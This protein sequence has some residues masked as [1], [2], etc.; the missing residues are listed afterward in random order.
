MQLTM[1]AWLVLMAWAQTSYGSALYSFFTDLTIQ[2]GA[3]DPTTGKLLYSAC[4]SQNIPIFPLEKPNILDTK[5]TPRNGTALTAVGWGDWQFITAQVFWQTEDDTIVQGKYI[6]NMTTGKLVRDREFQISAAAGVDSIHNQTGLS[7]VNLGEKDGYRLFYHDKDRKV[8]MLWYTDDD[9]WNDGGAI[10]QDTAGGMALG[11]TIHDLK[12]ITVPFPK[13]SENIEL[14][15]LDK[16]GLWTLDAFPNK[17]LGPYTNNTLPADMF[18]SLED[19]ADF[20]LPAWNSSLEAIGA[21]V[22]RDRSRTR[23]IFYI[24]D[25]KKIHEVKSTNSGWQLGSNQTERTWPVADNAS[26]GLAVVSQQSEGKAW[27]YYWSNETIVQAFKDYD[28][29]WVDAEALPQKVPTNGTDDKK[30]KDRPTQEDGPDPEGSKGLSSG[31]KTG[32][33]VGVGIGV[34]ALLIDVLAWL[35]TKRR[36]ERAHQE[37]VSGIVEVG[38]SPLEPRL[39]VF[40]EDLPRENERVEPS[41]MAGQ[42]RP[43][44]LSHH[45]SVVY[46]LPEHHA[47]G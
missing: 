15:R 19:E 11:S 46:E 28:G 34:G 7:I 14:S 36:R 39:Y 30:P 33:G 8:K 4:N 43:A 20:S 5:E 24:G 35:W 37:K 18:W 38:G 10:S 12:N 29:D 2:V 47:R 16:S 41:E 3:Q 1:L 22:D 9:G 23:S 21:A 42:G 40:K 32:I 26:S 27:L 13:D 25:D 44:E 31:A 17:F 6:C 45:D